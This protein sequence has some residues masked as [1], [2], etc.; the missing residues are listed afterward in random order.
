MKTVIKTSIGRP[1]LRLY[2][3]L[4]AIALEFLALSPGMRA[5]TPPPDGGYPGANTAEGQD[6]LLSLTTGGYNTAIGFESLRTN[7]TGQFNTGVG[8]LTLYFNTGDQNTANGAAA[9]VYNT[10]GTFKHSQRS[11][12]AL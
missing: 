10:T 3:I 2:F 8:A 6:A 4:T 12:R 5:V 7:T 11:L 1:F 9:L